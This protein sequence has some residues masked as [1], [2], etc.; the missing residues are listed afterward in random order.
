MWLARQ[1]GHSST[2]MLFERFGKWIDTPGA[3]T[4]H[5]KIEAMFDDWSEGA[6]AEI[7]PGLSQ[8]SSPGAPRC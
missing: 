6:D 8:D 4:E 3:S 1:M 2:K 5:L 7:G